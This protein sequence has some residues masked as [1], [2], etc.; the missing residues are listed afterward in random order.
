MQVQPLSSTAMQ[1]ER[2]RAELLAP[3][4]YEAEPPE[5]TDRLLQAIMAEATQGV[6]PTSLAL[7]GFDWLMHLSMSPGKW[8]QLVRKAWKKDMRWINYA[9]H[10][11]FGQPSNR[12]SSR[13][14]K[15][16]AF[17]ANSGSAGRTT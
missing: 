17:A 14:R 11:S 3:H 9:I 5:D 2:Q 15:T 4:G 6:A 16:G 10:V 7:A 13:C 8:Q 1:F 12:A